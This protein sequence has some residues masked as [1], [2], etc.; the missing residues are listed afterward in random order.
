MDEAYRAYRATGGG[1][2]HSGRTLRL[3]A[4]VGLLLAMVLVAASC[5]DAPPPERDDPNN[6]SINNEAADMGPPSSRDAGASSADDAEIDYDEEPELDL[7]ADA[8]LDLLTERPWR[9]QLEGDWYAI[10]AHQKLPE[11][12]GEV[13]ALRFEDDGEVRVERASSRE[14]DW[15]W[16]PNGRVHVYGLSV[17]GD[18]EASE[19]LLE[20]V[21]RDGRMVALLSESYMG[22]SLRFEPRGESVVEP[23]ALSGLWRSTER[24]T[25]YREREFYLAM[26]VQGPRAEYGVVRNGVFVVR[27]AH[28]IGAMTFDT[29]QTFWFF[30]PPTSRG[31]P[32]LAGEVV[33]TPST[34]DSDDVAVY[35][36]LRVDDT[37]EMTD[38]PIFQSVLLEPV[39]SF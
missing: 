28:E 12:V 23:G 14:G 37:Y 13:V 35:A 10:V 2:L 39:L 15:E 9:E 1:S 8:R 25:D 31:V 3:R 26:Q 30:E 17:D 27:S 32:S 22:K 7:G 6:W 21:V 18:D 20:P 33:V 4:P 5:G 29:G 11:T 38:T 16:L 19:F 36:P 34:R 24:V